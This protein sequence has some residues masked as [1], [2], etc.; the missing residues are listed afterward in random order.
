MFKY[1]CMKLCLYASISMYCNAYKHV[2]QCIQVSGTTFGVTLFL[3]RL[4]GCRCAAGE[5]L[6]P[7]ILCKG[8]I[9]YSSWMGGGPAGALFGVS[10]YGWTERVNFLS[11]FKK[12]FCQQF[13]T[14]YLI[15]ESYCLST[16]TTHIRP[17][18]LLRWPK[19]CVHAFLPT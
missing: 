10:K 1:T 11:W 5:Q 17:L 16:T 15:Q 8:K 9:F 2:L 7:Y 14:F 3:S 6:P 12:M 4:L 19:K 13:N 18:S